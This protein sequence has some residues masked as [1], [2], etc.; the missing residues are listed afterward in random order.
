MPNM[1]WQRIGIGL[2][3]VLLSSLALAQSRALRDIRFGDSFAVVTWKVC[4]DPA[5]TTGDGSPVAGSPTGSPEQCVYRGLVYTE[6]AAY[7]YRLRFQFYDDRL[8]RIWFLSPAMAADAFDALVMPSHDNLVQSISRSHGYPDTSRSVE[9]STI[10]LG[11]F[12]WSNIWN[13]NADGVAFVVGIARNDA[14]FSAVLIAED[15]RL[16]DLYERSL[17]DTEPSG[18]QDEHRTQSERWRWP[19]G[20]TGPRPHTTRAASIPG[21]LSRYRRL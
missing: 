17:E 16:R 5:F 9:V 14:T 21:P 8:F 11:Q 13:T 15:S 4:H 6:V 3:V 18:W 7:P 12:S 20:H 10:E 2:A 19:P 1:R